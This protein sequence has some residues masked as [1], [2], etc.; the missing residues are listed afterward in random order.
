MSAN[1]RRRG[2]SRRQMLR[3]LAQGTTAAGLGA[4][5]AACGGSSAPQAGEQSNAAQG[6]ASQAGAQSTPAGEAQAPAQSSGGGTTIQFITPAALGTERDLYTSFVNNFQKDNP[7]IK[8]NVSFEAW[9]DYMTKLPTI[10][11]SGAVPDVIHQHM[12]IVQDYGARGAL[13][14]LTPLMERDKVSKDDYIPA[15][16]DSFSNQGVTYALPKD[17]AAWGIYY[18]KAMFDAASLPYP[19]DDWTLDDF[20]KYALELTRD[21]NGNPASSPNFDAA[22][23]KQWG[24]NWL[25][26]TPTTS[27]ITRGFVKAYGGDWYN[28]QYTETLITDPKVQAYFKLMADMRCKQHASPAA[29]QAQAQGDPFRTGLVAM[30]HGFHSTDYFCRQEKVT[31]PWDVTFLPS[32]PGGQFVPVGAS[33]WAIPAKAANQDAAWELVKYLTSAEV[34]KTIGEQKRW[35]LSRKEAIDSI[36]PDNPT[37]GFKK[38]HVDPLTGNSDRTVISFKFPAKQSQIKQIYSTEFDAVWTCSSDD[39]AGAS[40]TVKQQVDEVLQS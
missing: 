16:F 38:V 11:A 2:M 4:L 36:I 30:I 8:V 13:L 5:I 14:D 20:A 12:S 40:E 19:K 28:E 34:Q 35:G 33:G 17:S 18:N 1:D 3:V 6:N 9:D 10:F 26:P 25:E 7:D 15:L 24:F 27:E 29:S 22:N 31:F 37:S 32:G 23:I 21:Q 39:I